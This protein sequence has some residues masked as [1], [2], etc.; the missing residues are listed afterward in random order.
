MRLLLKILYSDIH[1]RTSNEN[2]QTT[3]NY[4]VSIKMKLYIIFVRD[5]TLN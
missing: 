3:S 5:R 2:M 4:F 1:F